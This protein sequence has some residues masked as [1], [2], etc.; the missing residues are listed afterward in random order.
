MHCVRLALTQ[1]LDAGTALVSRLRTHSV[2]DELVLL[3]RVNLSLTMLYTLLLRSWYCITPATLSIFVLHTVRFNYASISAA[4]SLFLAR[5]CAASLLVVCW[6]RCQPSILPLQR[7]GLPGR[8]VLQS[9]TPPC[10][11]ISPE[12]DTFA[13]LVSCPDCSCCWVRSFPFFLSIHL[14]AVG[15]ALS[16]L[17]IDTA[18]SFMFFRLPPRLFSLTPVVLMINLITCWIVSA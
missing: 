13:V 18:C 14:P 11:A 8:L 16:F 7:S 12:S 2:T 1:H 9:P 15:C 17:L 4:W 10:D 5:H 6:L 3:P